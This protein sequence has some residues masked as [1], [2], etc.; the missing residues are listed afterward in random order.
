[1]QLLQETGSAS[2][3]RRR[4]RRRPYLLR[5]SWGVMTV[6]NTNLNLTISAASLAVSVVTLLI[7]VMG[8]L[9][10]LVAAAFVGGLVVGAVI[11][12]YETGDQ[13]T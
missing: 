1:M 12:H 6:K 13:E 10:A 7:T 9:A 8:A 4:A 5:V 11:T 3:S 2:D